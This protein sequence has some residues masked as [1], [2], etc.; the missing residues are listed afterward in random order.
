MM[1]F[2]L[3]ITK[4]I[5]ATTIAL[6]FASCRFDVD[7][8]PGLEGDGN[9]VTE[10]RNNDTPFTAIEI[11]RGLELEVEQSSERSIS[12]VADKNLQQHITTEV[13]NGILTITTD[14]DINDA[15]SKKIIVKLPD[16]TS[17]QASSGAFIE[18]L[19]T[20]KGQ[21]IGLTTSSAGEIKISVEADNVTVESSSGSNVRLKGKAFKLETDA[22]S[23]SVI[24]AEAMLANDVI[25]DASSGSVTSVYPLGSLKA[26]ASSGSSVT[27]HNEPKNISRDA[28]SG[29]SITKE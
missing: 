13:N 2:I 8:G 7:L 25:S 16:I 22:S 12:V 9:V 23:G 11:S 20:I 18:S 1:R 5:V 15:S 29:G 24:D 10:N 26:E 19:N 27:Y 6:L 28:S 17:L 3:F 14:V 4:I 21:N